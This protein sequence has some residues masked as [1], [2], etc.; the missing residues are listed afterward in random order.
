MK[1]VY[2]HGI[3]WMRRKTLNEVYD[4][5]LQQLYRVDCMDPT[6]I[7]LPKWKWFYSN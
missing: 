1:K 7:E 4:Y 5:V 6:G 2:V 3:G